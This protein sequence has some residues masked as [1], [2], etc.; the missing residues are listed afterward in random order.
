MVIDAIKDFFSIT[1]ISIPS[2]IFC[3][4]LKHML[5]LLKITKS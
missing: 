1:F 4:K 2:L 3:K 5:I